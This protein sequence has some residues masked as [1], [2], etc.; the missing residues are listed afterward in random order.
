MKKYIL[1]SLSM[2]LVLF[3]CTGDDDICT[4]GEA[5]PRMK[6]KFK[7]AN[8]KLLQMSTLIIG[9][10]Y[11]SGTPTEVLNSTDVDSVMIPLRIDESKYTDVYI[12]TSATGPTSVVRVNYTTSSQYVSPACGIKRLYREVTADL[13]Q[14]NP[15]KKI[16][17]EQTEI[18]DEDKT[19]FYFIF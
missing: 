10:D 4:N 11:G 19:H 2:L 6:V 5:T 17:S 15:V 3:S 16:Q 7:D 8:N 1:L 13:E 12:K 9:V 14:K 18:T